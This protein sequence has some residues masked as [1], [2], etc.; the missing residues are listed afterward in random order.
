LCGQ[1]LYF[2]KKCSEL[3]Q[4]VAYSTSAMGFVMKPGFNI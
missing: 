3:R 1:L 4:C 2:T